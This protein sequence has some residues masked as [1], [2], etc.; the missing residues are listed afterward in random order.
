MLLAIQMLIEN[1]RGG[2][3]I[4]T[5]NIYVPLCEISCCLLYPFSKLQNILLLLTVCA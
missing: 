2:I 3:I 5:Y 1:V 4:Y